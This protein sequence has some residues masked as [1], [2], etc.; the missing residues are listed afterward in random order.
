M[1][2]LGRDVKKTQWDRD[3]DTETEK[4]RETEVYLEVLVVWSLGVT[5]RPGP[6]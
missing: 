1:T 3:R 5:G 4:H 2:I 6:G